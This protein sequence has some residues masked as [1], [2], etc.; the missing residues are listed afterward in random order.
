MFFKADFGN[1]LDAWSSATLSASERRM[2]LASWVAAAW[3][4]L[5]QEAEF[6]R[7]AFVSTGFLFAS[8]GSENANI[9]IRGAPDYDFT[10]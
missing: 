3:A 10:A 1:N 4:I 6:L 9:K 2:K 7:S 5:S 8:D